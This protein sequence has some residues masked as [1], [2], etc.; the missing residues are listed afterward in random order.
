[1]AEARIVQSLMLIS[2]V[3]A[4]LPR[5]LRI[6]GKAGQACAILSF[7]LLAG[8]IFYVIWADF[9]HSG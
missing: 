3:S 2:M 1:M 8:A 9:L 7:L 4:L 6:G 5:I